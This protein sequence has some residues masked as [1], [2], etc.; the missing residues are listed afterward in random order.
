MG[1]SE[2]DEGLVSEGRLKPMPR[3][4]LLIALLLLC[5][6]RRSGGGGEMTKDRIL[7]P[8]DELLLFR[9]RVDEDEDPAGR[10]PLRSDFLHTSSS[11][12]GLPG[13][14]LLSSLLPVAQY[15]VQ[16]LL[17]E[18]LCCVIENT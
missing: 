8:V 10:L 14:L 18:S 3:L 11:A 13:P 7:L 1:S 16:I 6:L 12:D 17:N 4:A 5:M 9:L 2:D 15:T